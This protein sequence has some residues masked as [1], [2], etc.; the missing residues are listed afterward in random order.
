LSYVSPSEKP[1]DIPGV[2]APRLTGTGYSLTVK[3]LLQVALDFF[4]PV[5]PAV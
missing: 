2:V 3:Q 4:Q 5:G 1:N